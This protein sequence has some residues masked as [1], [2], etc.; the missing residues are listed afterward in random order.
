[1]YLLDYVCIY[2]IINSLSIKLCSYSFSYLFQLFI[3]QLVKY[4][5]N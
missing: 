4:S 2:L 1:M 5:Y 3:K